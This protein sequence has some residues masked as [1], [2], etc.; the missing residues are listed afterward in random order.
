M[1][2]IRLV[3]LLFF[4][5]QNALLFAHT[6]VERISFDI[7]QEEYPVFLNV[8]MSDTGYV[9]EIPKSILDRDI[10]MANRVLRSTGSSIYQHAGSLLNTRVIQFNK[11]NNRQIKI[12]FKEKNDIMNIVRFG[13]FKT[14]FTIIDHDN[15]NEIYRVDFT[16]FIH[17]D[18]ELLSLGVKEYVKER[19]EIIAVNSYDDHLNLQTRMTY[20][21]GLETTTEDYQSSFVLL[22]KNPMKVRVADKR[23]GYF[24]EKPNLF[25]TLQNKEYES[26]VTRFRLEPKPEDRERYLKG[27]LVEPQKPIVFYIDYTAP[28]KW[29]KY[30]VQGIQ[31]WQVAFEKA[32]FKNAIYARRAP[33]D[34]VGWHLY[35][36]KH[37][38]V[39][40]QPNSS[41]NATGGRIHDPRSGEI[42]TAHVQWYHNAMKNFQEW[43]MIQAGPNDPK[44]RTLELDEA[45]LG[46]QVRLL[47]AHEVGHCLGLRH[48]FI[49]SSHSPVDSLRSVSYLKESGIGASIMEYY[50]F[51]YVAQPEDNIPRE[52]LGTRVGIYDKWAIAWGYRWF[53]EEWSVMEEEEFLRKWT[54]DELAKDKRLMCVVDY[55]FSPNDARVFQE[56]IGDDV[57]KASEYGIKNLHVVKKNLEEWTTSPINDFSDFKHLTQGLF[58][59]YDLYMGHVSNTVRL[60]MDTSSFEG[61]QQHLLTYVPK[62]KRKNGIKF[63]K[64]HLFDMQPWLLENNVD[65]VRKT[66]LDMESELIKSRERVLDNLI[67]LRTSQSLHLAN[68]G[69][70]LSDEYVFEE[71]LLDLKDV[72]FEELSTQR[73]IS[74]DRQ[75]LQASFVDRI[76]S[77][78]SAKFVADILQEELA[79]SM[80]SFGDRDSRQHIQALLIRIKSLANPEVLQALISKQKTEQLER[81]TNNYRH[82]SCCDE[83]STVLNH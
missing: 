72:L 3:I 1:K 13:S 66:E 82:Y 73:V 39:I 28:L 50:R 12:S 2:N 62:L 78:S 23:V 79:K 14:I 47:A 67:S 57:I 77:L 26:I 36:A 53:P 46:E 24:E 20:V 33:V 18:Y 68:A 38:G 41:A 17:E 48:N 35:D 45:I 25:D 21:S 63:L 74:R 43:Y 76:M 64:Q 8:K 31:D 40:Y 75:I 42:I 61:K 55:G 10:L 52:L 19:S 27:E 56:D 22:P 59:Q 70:P 51:N 30:M 34:S 65:I 32:G 29:V 69:T 7:R 58:R 44:G 9:L 49:A 60:G 5:L 80:T 15:P 16:D 6:M 83:G 37:N 4:V 71:L 54:T 81:A 11:I